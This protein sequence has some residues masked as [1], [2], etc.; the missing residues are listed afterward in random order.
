MDCS[1]LSFAAA[2]VAL[3]ASLRISFYQ[4]IFQRKINLQTLLIIYDHISHNSITIYYLSVLK[5][6]V[7]FFEYVKKVL[8]EDQLKT[9]LFEVYC[10]PEYLHFFLIGERLICAF[11]GM[12]LSNFDVLLLVLFFFLHIFVLLGLLLSSPFFLS[13][14]L[15]LLFPFHPVFFFYLLNFILDIKQRLL[16]EY[17]FLDSFNVRL[18][19]CIFLSIRIFVQSLLSD[20]ACKL[21]RIQSIKLLI[22]GLIS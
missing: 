12:L 11:L 13:L 18:I 15:H 16:L 1:A 19:I 20:F 8:L 2:R 7:V 3:M 10:L 5:F 21:S 9:L 22:F 14:F 4:G 17:F 6:G